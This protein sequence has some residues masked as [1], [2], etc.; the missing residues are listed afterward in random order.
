MSAQA[1]STAA[2]VAEMSYTTAILEADIPIKIAKD[3]GLELCEH[4]KAME[5]NQMG[6][7]QGDVSDLSSL[8]SS[9]SSSSASAVTDIDAAWQRVDEILL[10]AEGVLKPLRLARKPT[11]VPM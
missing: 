1:W 3:G 8:S 2:K 5:A 10:E 4:S 11:T 9:S 7:E 6:S